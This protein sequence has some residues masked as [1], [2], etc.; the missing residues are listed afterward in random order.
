MKLVPEW[1]H[2]IK[3]AWSI[4]LMLIAALL[5]GFNAC[6]FAFGDTVPHGY[7]LAVGMLA[8]MAAV[9]ARVVHQPRMRGAIDAG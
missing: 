6:W 9:V 4:R 3:R 1:R 2:I 5:D 7:F 8:S